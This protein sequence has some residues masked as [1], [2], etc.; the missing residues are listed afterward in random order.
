M[1]SLT[2]NGVVYNEMKGAFSSSPEDVLYRVVMNT[3]FPDTTY[4]N[5]SGGD[6]EYIPD[7]TY[8]QFLNFHRKFYHPSNSYIYLY[9]DMDME[10]RLNWMDEHYLSSFTAQEVDSQIS[11]Q[12]PFTQMAEKM[13]SYSITNAESEE[14][15]TY[16]SYNKVI[17]DSLDRELYQAFQILIMHCYLHRERR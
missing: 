7:L 4:A 17:G 5:E 6:P 9:G 15:N 2:Y 14:D 11:F 3:L 10:E 8:E 1:I 16:L 13:T 12:K